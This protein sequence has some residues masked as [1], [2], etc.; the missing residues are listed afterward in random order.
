MQIEKIKKQVSFSEDVINNEHKSS[1]S[2]NGLVLDVSEIKLGE[3]IEITTTYKNLNFSIAY[4]KNGLRHNKINDNGKIT[5]AFRFW[6]KYTNLIV[7]I[8]Y[9][10]DLCSNPT[11]DTPARTIWHRPKQSVKPIVAQITHAHL[12]KTHHISKPAEEKFNPQGFKI[13]ESW[14]LHGERYRDQ[15]R[16]CFTTWDNLGNITNQIF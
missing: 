8:Y 9:E 12:G 7:Q 1:L 3:Y 2:R 14:W 15:N 6:D 4:Y 5:P 11:P 16:A 13:Q 10:N